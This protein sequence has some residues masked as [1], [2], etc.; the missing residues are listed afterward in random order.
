M[1]ADSA[2]SNPDD[3]TNTETYPNQPLRDFLASV[4][5][6][7][8][9]LNT[10][11]VGLDAVEKGH[12]KPDALNISWNPKD[13]VAAAR[14]SR[15]FMLEAVLVRVAEALDEF[16]KA[17]ARM[18]RFSAIRSNWNSKTS[19]AEM[20]ADVAFEA[21]GPDSYLAVGA[22]LLVHWRNRVVHPRSRAS[23]TPIQ[24]KKLV[25]SEKEIDEGFAGLSVNRLLADFESGQATLKDITSL[26]AMSIRLTRQIDKAV[27]VLAV[28]DLH[29][30]MDYYGLNVRIAE[31]EMQTTPAKRNASVLRFLKSTAP[32]LAEV[33]CRLNLT[34]DAS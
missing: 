28:H 2:G 11:V 6:T 29:A 24:R 16:V 32:G 27:A 5:E 9:N 21:V 26:V 1:K 34:I 8:A 14:K 30:L 23:L 7:V 33:Y 31:I 15:R 17:M 18:P 19:R 22:V 3:A 13:R 12:E 25:D 20:L 10:A 4:G